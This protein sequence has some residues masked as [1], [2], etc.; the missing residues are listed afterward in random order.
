M[1]IDTNEICTSVRVVAASRVTELDASPPGGDHDPVGSDVP[2]YWTYYAAARL[3]LR[4]PSAS[5]RRAGGMLR[6]VGLSRGTEDI[7]SGIMVG[8]EWPYGV[9]GV[10]GVATDF[11]VGGSGS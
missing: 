2:R 3:S 4:P 5:A 1:Y 6:K 7:K 11:R 8:K 9:V 10:S